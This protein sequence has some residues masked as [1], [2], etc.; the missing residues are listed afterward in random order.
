VSVSIIPAADRTP[1]DK[2]RILLFSYP[3]ASVEE[4]PSMIAAVTEALGL[5]SETNAFSN[6]V[7]RV[8]LTGP[9]QPHLTLV[10]LPGLIH[11]QN[12]Q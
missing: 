1:E 8:E 10:D 11:A 2:T 9:R 12:K 4:L 5:G 3:Q 7:L 6:D